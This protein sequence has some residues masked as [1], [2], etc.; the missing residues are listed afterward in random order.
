MKN[1]PDPF[2]KPTTLPQTLVARRR[3]RGLSI[4]G[5]A[6]TAGVDPGTWGD[7]ERG[8]S[9]DRPQGESTSCHLL[10]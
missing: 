6:E 3:E 5:A 4:K 8:H 7:W 9:G 10:R 1:G 2:L